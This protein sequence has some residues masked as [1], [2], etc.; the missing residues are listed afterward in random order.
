M[1]AQSFS[2]LPGGF[3]GDH[4]AMESSFNGTAK[5]F[6]SPGGFNGGYGAFK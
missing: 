6:S 2:L 1:A 5:I 4:A 3:N